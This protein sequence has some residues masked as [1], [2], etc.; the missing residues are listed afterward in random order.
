MSIK[1]N[2]LKTKSVCKVTFRCPKE[3]A[4]SASSVCLVGDFNNW[5]HKANPMKSLKDGAYTTTIDLQ[6]NR[7]YQFKYLIDGSKWSNDGEADKYI[8]TIYGDS[9]NSVIEI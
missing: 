8:P 7:E 1:K 6:I 9:E 2:Y 3:T 4:A 5:N